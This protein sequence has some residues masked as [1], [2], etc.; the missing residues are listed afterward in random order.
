MKTEFKGT[1]GNWEL[2]DD[3]RNVCVLVKPQTYKTIC[4]NFYNTKWQYDAKLISCAPQMLKI[5]QLIRIRYN[6]QS[7]CEKEI[8]E[9]IKKATT[10]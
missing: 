2:S 1:K 5:L 6:I 10:I 8:D 9:L 4:S 7:E 3:K